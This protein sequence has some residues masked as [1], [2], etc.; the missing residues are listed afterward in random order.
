VTVQSREYLH[1]PK[2]Q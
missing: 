1:L 2:S